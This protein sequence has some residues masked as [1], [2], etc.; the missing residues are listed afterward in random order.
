[1]KDQPRAAVGRFFRVPALASTKNTVPMPVRAMSRAAAGLDQAPGKTAPRPYDTGPEIHVGFPSI[2]SRTSSATPVSVRS[3]Q[4]LGIRPL[5]VDADALAELLHDSA[6]AGLGPNL[7]GQA[8][9][10]LRL[11]MDDVDRLGGHG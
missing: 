9:G 4:A 1:M 6:P 8:T 3:A 10:R 5:S 11:A 7:G 2:S